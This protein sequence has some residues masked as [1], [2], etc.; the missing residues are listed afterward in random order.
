MIAALLSAVG[1]FLRTALTGRPARRRSAGPSLLLYGLAAAVIARM[2]SLPIAL[3]AGMGIGVIDQSRLLRRPATPRS[4]TRSCSSSSLV[5]PAA[6]ARQAVPGRGHRRRDAGGRSRS[7]ARSRPSCASVREVVIGQ[8]VVRAV[9]RRCARAGAA[10]PGRHRAAQDVASLLIVYA[11]VGVSLVVL[12]GWA[13]QISLGQFAF[14]GVGAAVAGGLAANHGVDFFVRLFAAGLAGAAVAVADRPARAAI[15][16]LFLAVTTLAFAVTVAVLLPQPRVLRL[17][18]ARAGRASS[19]G[20]VLLRAL[21]RSRSDHALLLPLPGLP[22]AWRCSL[23]AVA[24]PQPLGP[25]AHRRPR[26]R[27][28]GAGLRRQPGPHPAGRLRHLRLHRRR[29]RRP[30]R[31]RPGQSSTPTTFTPE[32]SI[33]VFAMAVIGGLDVAARRRARR[34]LRRRASSSFLRQRLRRCSPA[35]SGCCVLLLFLPGGLSEIGFT[36]SATRFL[37]WVAAQERHPRAEP[38]GRLARRRGPTEEAEAVECRRRRSEHVG[39]VDDGRLSGTRP[40]VSG[41]AALRSK[42]TGRRARRSR[43]SCCSASTSST[44]STRRRSACWRRTSAT[45]STSTEPASQRSVAVVQPSSSCLGRARRR[46][47]PTASTG[48]GWPRSAAPGR[49]RVF[50]VCTGLS[51]VSVV[52]ARPRPL[53]RRPRP[54][55]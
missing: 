3:V 46:T 21:R 41:D 4:P 10:V 47:T 28:G 11:I 45:A 15:Q 17:A 34:G 27:P 35:G 53:R 6:A 40:P 37:R 42:I 23:A 12:T 50:S 44:S 24:A 48:C 2:E 31:P 26:Q 14:A 20:R 9:V 54:S 5:A 39:Q 51:A 36:G 7:S 18:A 25:D 16:G 1:V 55:R 22:R 32:Q 30:A 38:G 52:A 13:G 49:G 33:A 29:R 43:C 8:W 19:T